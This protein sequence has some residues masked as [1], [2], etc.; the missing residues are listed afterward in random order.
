MF[1]SLTIGEPVLFGRVRIEMIDEND[2]KGTAEIAWIENDGYNAP[3]YSAF[4][5]VPWQDSNWSY[6]GNCSLEE[7][8]ER[9]KNHLEHALSRCHLC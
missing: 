5:T 9:A 7:A 8:I 3:H 2:N 6:I 1:K 4:L